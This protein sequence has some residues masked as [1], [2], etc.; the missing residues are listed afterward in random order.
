MARSRVIA[1]I[2]LLTAAAASLSASGQSGIYAAVERVVFEPASGPPERVQVWGAFALMERG[3]AG[4]TGGPG[5]TGY[6]YRQP[7]KGFMYF[8]VP[9]K[10]AELVRREWKD[11][12]SAAGTPQVV[13]FGYWDNYRGDGTPTVRPASAKAENPDVY[14][15]NIGPTKL[16]RGPAGGIVDAL[17]KLIES[18]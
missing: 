14:L 8:R 16:S 5:F 1:V 18:R 9:E 12:A 7:A 6:V 4:S 10:D 17:L 15:T 13:A 2:A 3:G 11:L